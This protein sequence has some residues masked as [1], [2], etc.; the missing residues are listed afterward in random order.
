MGLWAAYLLLIP[1]SFY[2]VF[3]A[4]T[5][6][7]ASR[8]YLH[9]KFNRGRF[10]D[11]P[12]AYRHFFC[13]GQLL[14]DRV[15]IAVHPERFKVEEDGFSH[16]LNAVQE[17]KGLVLLGAHVGGW[18]AA[19]SLLANRNVTVNVVM[20]EGEEEKIRQLIKKSAYADQLRVISVGGSPEDSL[21]LIAALNR[22]EVIA[23]HGD[24]SL[25]GRALTLP[26]LGAPADFPLWPYAVA[27]AAKAPLI[28][29]FAARTGMY[30]YRLKA[31]PAQTPRMER[32]GREKAPLGEYVREYVSHLEQFLAE[33]P[34][35]WLNFYPF[36]KRP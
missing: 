17:N 2:F 27:A 34:F 4:P 29:T 26:F 18:E 28:H 14:I 11:L 1:V 33:Y 36:W 31:W 13:F 30:R 20:F 3:F 21:A 7:Q 9:R 10:Y 22:G 19:M 35:Q 12:D 5:A 6:R 32:V 24:R 23:M 8:E 25:G 16:I 15:A